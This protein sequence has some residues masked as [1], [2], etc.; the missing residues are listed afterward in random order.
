MN[1]GRP[2]HV[3]SDASEHIWESLSGSLRHVLFETSLADSLPRLAG[4]PVLIIHGSEDGLADSDELCRLAVK[5]NAEFLCVAGDHHLPLAAPESVA[6]A[7]EYF[8]ARTAAS[9]PTSAS[10]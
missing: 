10:E 2:G 3:A 8:L 6:E 5:T 4:I 7:I 1:P 9:G